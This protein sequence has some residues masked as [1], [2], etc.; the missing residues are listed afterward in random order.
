M[1]ERKH[2]GEGGSETPNNV[3]VLLLPMFICFRELLFDRSTSSIE[4]VGWT[5]SWK[6]P[7][8]DT[9]GQD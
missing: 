4:S 7:Y 3:L 8:K 6:R 2:R 5:S 1:G 9:D